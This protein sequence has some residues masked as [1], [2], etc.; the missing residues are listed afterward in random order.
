MLSIQ[1]LSIEVW[2]YEGAL[3]WWK[4]IYV[5]AIIPKTVV[6]IVLGTTTMLIQQLLSHFTQKDIFNELE[7]NMKEGCDI[8]LDQSLRNI[9]AKKNLQK[10]P[11]TIHYIQFHFFKL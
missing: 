1:N 8:T 11:L 4:N 3:Q 9:K 10:Q 6:L 5:T 2:R 7:K